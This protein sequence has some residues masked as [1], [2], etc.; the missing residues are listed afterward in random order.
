MSSYSSHIVLILIVVDFYTSQGQVTN[1]LA[2]NLL[3]P[4]TWAYFFFLVPKFRGIQKVRAFE[5]YRNYG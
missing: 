4:S 2:N 5:G 3:A 1:I